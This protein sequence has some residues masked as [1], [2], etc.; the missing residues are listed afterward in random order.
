MGFPPTARSRACAYG[1]AVAGRLDELA[2]AEFFACRFSRVS[3]H[4]FPDGY[5]GTEVQEGDVLEAEGKWQR[6]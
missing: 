4:C 1:P 3:C 5:N 6:V 2:H